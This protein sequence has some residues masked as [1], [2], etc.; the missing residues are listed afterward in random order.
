MKVLESIAPVTAEE[1]ASVAPSVDNIERFRRR[2]EPSNGQAPAQ[3][4]NVNTQSGVAEET[5]GQS[6]EAVPASN[7]QAETQVNNVQST[8]AAPANNQQGGEADAKSEESEDAESESASG[9][10]SQVET[11][12]GNIA[13]AM[14]QQSDA[15]P[16][17]DPRNPPTS[18][19]EGNEPVK[20][21]HPLTPKYVPQPPAPPPPQPPAPP[22]APPVMVV[23]TIK[24]LPDMIHYH[25]D[26]LG[27]SRYSMQPKVKPQLTQDK[28]SGEGS[29]TIQSKGLSADEAAFVSALHNDNEAVAE[30]PK[31]A[32]LPGSEGAIE[33][34]ED[35]YSGDEESSASGD[36][37]E[38]VS[39][40][41]NNSDDDSGSAS[42]DDS[43]SESIS[44]D[45]SESSASGDKRSEIEVQSSSGANFLSGDRAESGDSED[46]SEEDELPGNTGA[47]KDI[48]KIVKNAQKTADAGK[49]KKTVQQA[50][51][52][53]NQDKQLE[54]STAKAPQK[55]AITTKEVD[56]TPE[57]SGMPPAA[58]TSHTF[59][60][61]NDDDDD[62][63]GDIQGSASGQLSDPIDHITRPYHDP[64][65]IKEE[66]AE[67][68]H[69]TEKA[70]Q[71]QVP[72]PAKAAVKG[73]ASTKDQESNLL[74]SI[75][76]SESGTGSGSGSGTDDLFQSDSEE[77]LPGSVGAMGP[78]LMT[79][80]NLAASGDNSDA[81][82]S[83]ASGSGS[84][85]TTPSS[86]YK[87]DNIATVAGSA[88]TESKTEASGM[89]LG[90][91]EGASGSGEEILPGSVGNND[92]NEVQPLT[93]SG[94][95]ITSGISTAS[96]S[97]SGSENSA[98]SVSSTENINAEPQK[99]SDSD[100]GSGL[101]SGSSQ[102]SKDQENV[103]NVPAAR[104]VVL[105]TKSVMEATASNQTKTLP[106]S[107]GVEDSISASG[108][109]IPEGS[110]IESSD[111]SGAGSIEEQEV[112][113]QYKKNQL[114][115][116]SV[117]ETSGQ[118]AVGDLA[119]DGSGVAT[120][121][122]ISGETQPVTVKMPTLNLDK[123]SAIKA[124][125][126]SVGLNDVP[127]ALGSGVG[128]ALEIEGSSDAMEGSGVSGTL[129]F[130][131]VTNPEE[132]VLKVA[133]NAAKS[134]GESL[135]TETEGSAKTH[136]SGEN[137]HDIPSSGDLDDE[138]EPDVEIEEEVRID[139]I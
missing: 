54:Q 69:P 16:K 79:M 53:K 77:Q 48:E 23:T 90:F 112:L 81:S 119:G 70:T 78:N 21:P 94:E 55:S 84:A 8:Q 133:G 110:S 132:A 36:S 124:A 28:G 118:E 66:P 5:S 26:T 93:G 6:G 85:E 31:T 17:Y 116:E 60:E 12:S 111:A 137:R 99:P 115:E 121:Q 134:N 42:G 9:S 65:V 46:E 27:K 109:G 129:E 76:D 88:V 95:E 113:P 49:I 29:G 40:K 61:S 25:N 62:T 135:Q 136:S 18:S 102:A 71:D 59:A 73:E 45:G 125:L 105:P 138:P 74:N 1:D 30:T 108:S 47:I 3:L 104:T 13:S 120:T 96:D 22:P 14:N 100:S 11:E 82:E 87:K 91:P 33:E 43:S 56:I 10:E 19:V 122:T 128:S 4:D 2:V 68:R 63:S 130:T 117:A 15:A 34:K 41:E 97:G 127:V 83:S 106:G 64:S 92:K 38:D 75:A 72:E 24:P 7:K 44:D 107:L 123:E 101:E 52:A 89:D 103:D 57:G 51:E 67:P 139:L 58:V 131:P 35:D 39:T 50:V 126:G 20:V 86:N 37:S 114:T 80:N 32:S 98:E